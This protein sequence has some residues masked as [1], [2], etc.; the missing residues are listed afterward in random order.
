MSS[1]LQ[2]LFRNRRALLWICQ[3]YDLEPHETPHDYDLPE[4][5]AASRYRS[6][7]N[8]N[9][10]GLASRYW[11]ALWLEG[12]RSPVLTALRTASETRLPVVLSSEADA[13][14]KV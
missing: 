8:D 6:T 2:Q 1:D 3:Q 12:A 14:A 10:T 4:P 13:T 5:Q 9:D 11:T 7:I